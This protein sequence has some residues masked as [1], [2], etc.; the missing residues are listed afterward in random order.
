MEEDSP[1]PEESPKRIRKISIHN[2]ADRRQEIAKQV[3][4]AADDTGFFILVNQDY[5]S[6]REIKEAF[7]IS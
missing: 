3:I 2:L 4:E 1:P 6:S 7:E 5:P